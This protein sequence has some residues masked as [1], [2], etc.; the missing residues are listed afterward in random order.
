MPVKIG[1]TNPVAVY[2]AEH[3]KASKLTQKQLE[4]RLGAV[5][6]TVSRWERG[7][8]RVDIPTL[9]AIAEALWGDSDRWED[10]LHHPDKPTPNQLLRQ[11]PE[12]DQRYFVKQLKNAIARG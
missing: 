11:L 4:S 1:P 12:D 5:H 10:L 7:E 6:M 8:V 3:R 9:G 2:I